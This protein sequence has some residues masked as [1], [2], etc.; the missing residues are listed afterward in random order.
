MLTSLA[1]IAPLA[2][3]RN[4]EQYLRRAL[5]FAN[6]PRRVL[7][8]EGVLAFARPPSIMSVGEFHYIP[9]PALRLASRAVFV[10]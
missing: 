8:F 7:A 4:S 9:H 2:C 10:S 3:R 5:A 6:W 1:S